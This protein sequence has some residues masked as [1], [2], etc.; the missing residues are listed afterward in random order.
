MTF[1]PEEVQAQAK[2]F[3]KLSRVMAELGRIPKAGENKYHKYKFATDA[4][5]ADAIRP[6]LAEHGV[7]LFPSIP[8]VQT[9][10]FERNGKMQT[11][12]LAKFTFTFC[13]GE[14][15]ATWASE[16]F[17][18]SEDTGDKGVNKAATAALKYFLLKT[19]ILSTGDP[20]DETDSGVPSQ[21]AP[22]TTRQEQF[23][24][25]DFITFMDGYGVAPEEISD[26]LKERGI[27]GGTDYE[28]MK[29]DV[30][31]WMKAQQEAA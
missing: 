18:E 1:T 2:L 3:M 16:W 11:H 6:L 5:V 7:F 9:T 15:G 8:E 19:F 13:D 4:D 23:T 26:W 10:S 17:G 22:Q 28:R 31:K 30:V 14:T 20:A 12:T 24:R 25:A 21:P 29:N 27:A